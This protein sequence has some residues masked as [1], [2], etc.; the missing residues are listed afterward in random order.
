MTD[1][2]HDTIIVTE[3]K[4]DSTDCGIDERND[5]AITSKDDD[6]FSVRRFFRL[7]RSVLIV[8]MFVNSILGGVGILICGDRRRLDSIIEGKACFPTTTTTTWREEACRHVANLLRGT[9]PYR[10][11]T[12]NLIPIRRPKRSGNDHEDDENEGKDNV[13]RDDNETI[14]E[15]VTV[16]SPLEGVFGWITPAMFAE[17]QNSSPHHYHVEPTKEQLLLAERLANEVRSRIPDNFDARVKS[18]RWGGPDG[19]DWW[20]YDKTKKGGKGDGIYLLL[21]YLKI[22]K[23]PEDFRT[24]FPFELCTR[25]CHSTFAVTHTLEYR[26]KYKPW[27]LSESVLH[28]NRKGFIYSRGYEPRP[29]GQPSPSLVFLRP[30]I[31]VVESREAYIRALVNVL[32]Y[33]VADTLSRSSGTYGEYTIILD[34]SGF[35]LACVGTGVVDVM[36]NVRQTFRILKD[37]FP[38]QCGH[39]WLVN[40][41]GPAALFLKMIW[42]FLAEEF[43]DKIHVVPDDEQGRREALEPL[44]GGKESVPR[45]LG[46]EDDYE[47]NVDDYY[48]KDKRYAGK[49]VSE[50]VVAEY[51]TT[52]PYHARSSFL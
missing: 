22:M 45:W 31:H 2:H 24:V 46:G 12:R 30:G 10:R 21:T 52:M 43:R 25:R 41:G 3:R 49:I 48:R 20:D 5:P 4:E 18:V 13:G 29:P 26:E 1:H 27:L 50:E 35:R 44:L 37:H 7:L 11:P 6:D 19:V 34:S 38:D 36:I 14:V 17:E 51:Q 15:D 47:F 42:P 32:D 23:F 39:V 9:R 40:L 33:A 8:W 28:E 16:P